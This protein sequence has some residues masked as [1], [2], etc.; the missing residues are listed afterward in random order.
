[1]LT[2]IMHL[3]NLLTYFNILFIASIKTWTA[4]FAALNNPTIKRFANNQAV[5]CFFAYVL[6]K[7]LNF[8]GD[9]DRS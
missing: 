2:Y 5:V 3:R 6:R 8:T 4:E 7:L 9:L 1:M